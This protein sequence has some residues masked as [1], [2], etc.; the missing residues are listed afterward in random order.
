MSSSVMSGP[1]YHISSS[2]FVYHPHYGVVA[3]PPTTVSAATAFHQQYVQ[4]TSSTTMTTTTY[5]ST[6]EVYDPL[7]EDPMLNDGKGEMKY[8]AEFDWSHYT[9]DPSRARPTKGG[10]FTVVKSSSFKR[11]FCKVLRCLNLVEFRSKG[12]DILSVFHEEIPGVKLLDANDEKSS[13]AGYAKQFAVVRRYSHS[14][15]LMSL[16]WM[17]VFGELDQL[18]RL[19]IGR[20]G[21]KSVLETLGICPALLR[22]KGI[23]N[24]D[25]RLP[26]DTAVCSCT[27]RNVVDEP[28]TN[29]TDSPSEDGSSQKFLSPLSKSIKKRKKASKGTLLVRGSSPK[30]VLHINQLMPM[31]TLLG[32][33]FMLLLKLGASGENH[34]RQQSPGL[35]HQVPLYKEFEFPM[36]ISLLCRVK[37]DFSSFGTLRLTLC[38][39]SG[40][41]II[42]QKLHLDKD[43]ISSTAPRLFNL[44]DSSVRLMIFKGIEPHEYL[45]AVEILKKL[46][47]QWY[48]Q[49]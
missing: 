19:H 40:E 12:V 36:R 43:M 18:K 8:Q 13:E 30:V 11:L 46:N 44:V 41:K 6:V 48:H 24:E 49:S 4:Q 25:F 29:Q 9:S 16:S 20:V 7:V 15:P 35:E 22:I 21:K 34:H 38:L 3:P 27:N 10:R 14:N 32:K 39:S 33:D 26:R 17:K 2:P 47:S 28:A 5:S 42:S 1:A 45:V 23:W 31:K 37:V